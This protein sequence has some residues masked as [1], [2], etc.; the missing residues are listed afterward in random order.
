MA[1]ARKLPSGSWRCQV[2]SHM[3][4]GK[5]KYK[6]FTCTDPTPRGKRKCEA[7]AAAWS[8]RKEDR[9]D[10]NNLSFG[11]AVDAYIQSRENVLSP[12]TI[13]SYLSIRKL[14]LSDIE[15]I[16]I[17]DLTQADI[18]KQINQNAAHVSPKTVRNIH[19][20][21]SATLRTYRPE[22]AVNTTLPKKRPPEYH[23][24]TE[25]EIQRLTALVKG[26]D[27][28]IPVLLATVG[29]MRRGE[30]CALQAEDIDGNVA[31]VHLNMVRT[32]DM[33]EYMIKQPKSYAGDRYVTLPQYVVDLL[34]DHGRVTDLD[35]DQI[36]V[37]FHRFLIRNDLPVFRFHDLRHY[38][39]SIQHALGV[40]DSY[41]MQRG[42]WGNDGT[43][44]A[45]YR[46][47]LEENTKKMDDLT[48]AYFDKLC[49]TKCNTNNQE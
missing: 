44:K 8:A 7:M 2:F 22:F 26:T 18:Q 5:R 12:R 11:E 35:P 27:L 29:T 21:I 10:R 32:K 45:V 39:A 43:L 20:L 4:N 24:P 16:N 9:S 48:N 36:T 14:Y 37:R 42:G 6:S 3:E 13:S 34:P 15:Q 30:I 40:P 38:S 49:N 41:I 31:H 33:S 25:S 23:I 46:H 28:E 1:T 47:A 19:G 17:H